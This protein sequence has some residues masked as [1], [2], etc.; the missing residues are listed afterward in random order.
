MLMSNDVATALNHHRRLVRNVSLSFFVT[1]ENL[2][3]DL[4]L[5]YGEV[6]NY[7]LPL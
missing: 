7:D 4:R 3:M 6:E 1:Q 2:V 5:K